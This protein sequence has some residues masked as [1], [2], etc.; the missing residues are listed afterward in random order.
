MIR[1]KYKGTPVW[2]RVTRVHIPEGVKTFG[3]DHPYEAYRLI[4]YS[5]F[6]GLLTYQRLNLP[7]YTL[8]VG[9]FKSKDDETNLFNLLETNEL[10]IKKNIYNDSHNMVYENVY[11]GPE[12]E[13]DCEKTGIDIYN[14]IFDQEGE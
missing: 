3:K 7:E 6:N 8:Y 14:I 13:Y 5:L 11:S 12:N 2:L 9:R 10:H 4:Q 1:H